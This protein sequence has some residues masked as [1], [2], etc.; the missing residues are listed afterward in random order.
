M[1][2]FRFPCSY[3]QSDRSIIWNVIKSKNNNKKK[4]NKER[5][6]KEEKKELFLVGKLTTRASL[7]YVYYCRVVFWFTSFSLYIYRSILARLLTFRLIIS[8]ILTVPNFA[9]VCYILYSLLLNFIVPLQHPVAQWVKHWP[10]DLAVLGSIPTWGGDL[11]NRK[12]GSIAP[13]FLLSSIHRP[14]MTE[15]LLK[16]T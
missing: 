11:F 10:T 1:P 6:R 7:R 14:D 9:C 13:S 4:K 16:R 2:R 15:T 12:Q 8:H 5:K 3:R